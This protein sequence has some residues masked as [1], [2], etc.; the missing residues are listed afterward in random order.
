M[1]V[2]FKQ[3]DLE[4]SLIIDLWGGGANLNSV[5]SW[6]LIGRMRGT[7]TLLIDSNETANVVVNPT[8]ATRAVLTH[9][10]AIPETATLGLLLLEVEAHWPGAPQR[11]Q[12]FPRDQ[13]RITDDLDP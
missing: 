7:T 12:T 9:R 8:D 10:W 13:V 11:P 6:R 4:P 3:G 2:G 1:T 5:V